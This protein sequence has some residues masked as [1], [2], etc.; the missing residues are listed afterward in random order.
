VSGRKD[1]A[2]KIVK[3]LETRSDQNSSA[4]ANIALVYVGLGNNDQA[5]RWLNKAY[6]VRFNQ[7]TLLRPA[8]DPL[9][10]DSQFKDLRH[11]VG[12]LR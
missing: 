5:M 11:R 10:S 6:E 1:E 3:G 4:D 2:G 9:R 8:F 7:S 12:F